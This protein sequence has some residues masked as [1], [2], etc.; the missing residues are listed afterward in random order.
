[1]GGLFLFISANCAENSISN[2]ALWSHFSTN[3]GLPTNQ[4]RHVLEDNNGNLL[5]ITVND[6]IYRYDGLQF[7][8]LKINEKLPSLFIQKVIKDE[9]GRLWIAINYEGIWIYDFE[10]LY[11]F[12]FN[13]AFRK[14]HFTSLFID[15]SER[16][17]IDVNQVGLFR[18]D[19]KECLNLTEKYDLLRDDILQI[20]Q[21]DDQRY[22]FFYARSG[23]FQFNEQDQNSLTPILKNDQSILSYFLSNDGKYSLILM[24][25]KIIRLPE[26]RTVFQSERNF[27]GGYYF[28]FFMEDL[29]G[30]IWFF[31][32]ES[33]YCMENNDLHNFSIVNTERGAMFQDRFKNIWFATSTGIYKYI[34]PQISSYSIPSSG[35]NASLYEILNN[36][37][38]FEDKSGKVWFSYGT[39][40]IYN[41]DGQ[42]NSR[43]IWPDSLKNIKATD[44]A[45]DY[46]ENF[47]FATLGNGILRWDGEKFDRPIPELE[48][49]AKCI[50]TICVDSKNRLWIGEH[51]YL[52]HLNNPKSPLIEFSKFTEHRSFSPEVIVTSQLVDEANTV[53]FG[54]RSSTL[55][56]SENSQ[57]T[58]NPWLQFTGSYYY[59]IQNLHL[60]NNELW[61][62]LLRG[63]FKFDIPKNKINILGYSNQIPEFQESMPADQFEWVVSDFFYNTNS[64][65]LKNSNKKYKKLIGKNLYNISATIKDP[66]HGKWI[67]SYSVGLFFV[68]EDTLIHYNH[69]SGMPSHKISSLYRNK[70]GELFVGTLDYG[71]FKWKNGTFYQDDRMRTVGRSISLF[72]EDRAGR[73]WVGT[74]NNGLVQ[75]G[76][77]EVI[78]YSENLP[79]PSIWGIGESRDN[80]MYVC[81]RNADY[82]R[83]VGEHFEFLPRESILTDAH[84]REAFKGKSINF[85]DFFLEH[86]KLIS[87]GLACWDGNTLTRYSVDQGLPG[88]EIVDIAE[89][90]DGKLWVA[91]YNTGIAV[92][93]DDIFKPVTHP[94]ME[95]ISNLLS[96]YPGNDSSLWVLSL[97]EGIAFLKGDSCS[98]WGSDSKVISSNIKGLS[99]DSSGQPIL[100]SNR[101]LNYFED[102]TLYAFPEIDF[103]GEA[104]N[105][106]SPNFLCDD[107]R[108]VRLL[109][110]Y[111][112]F[113]EEN[114]E[115]AIGNFSTGNPTRNYMEIVGDWHLNHRSAD[116]IITLARACGVDPKDIR[117][118]QEPEGV[119]LFLHIK[120]GPEF[121]GM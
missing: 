120:S 89:T 95:K 70:N 80:R 5:V 26:R 13:S 19:G 105:A 51:S 87:P 24:N 103:H 40:Q 111:V 55:F 104:D 115:M 114:G 37:L 94:A 72:Y 116:K 4:I 6:G 45:Q 15:R 23:V 16:I 42:K 113:L 21:I 18:Y 75:L 58:K 109:K 38:I 99:F 121:I 30:R 11:P 86:D 117:V 65:Y 110:R 61:G 25:N 90:L 44:I 106:F 69:T 92:L 9:H 47:W 93:E 82:A 39:N 10:S 32:D 52:M 101:G 107:N 85:R 54:T 27:P 33:I 2:P 1:M 91:T 63:I 35:K 43:L 41:F 28:D 76:E 68:D 84:L 60:L 59:N 34:N 83:L 49:P 8:P 62:N 64:F 88:H 66:N 81:L 20:F 57:F 108:F 79:H 78:V 67:G 100:A 119:N 102:G 31:N 36:N 17:W 73:F 97:D 7:T 29:Q 14:E 46:D 3:N 77:N 96:F 53:W 22:H 12:E 71:M 50:S 98:H 112:C 74:L 56:K 118:G 48:F